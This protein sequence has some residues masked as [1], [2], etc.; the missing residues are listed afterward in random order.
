MNQMQVKCA[1]TPENVNKTGNL[2]ITGVLFWP[3]EQIFCM[4]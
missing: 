2:L 4:H 1:K 3:K